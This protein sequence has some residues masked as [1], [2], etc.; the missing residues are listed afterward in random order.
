MGCNTLKFQFLPAR[1]DTIDVPPKISMMSYP[2][3]R[4]GQ[5]E[6]VILAWTAPREAR[7]KASAFLTLFVSRLR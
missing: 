3:V 7:L 1:N 6:D 4:R 5:V 2:K